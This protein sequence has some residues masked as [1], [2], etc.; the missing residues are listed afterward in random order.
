MKT[1]PEASNGNIKVFL[2]KIKIVTPKQYHRLMY[3][4]I[5]YSNLFSEYFFFFI[6]FYHNLL[7][8]VNFTSYELLYTCCSYEFMNL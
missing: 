7:V 6:K 2:M 4:H 5:S 8:T 1:E 3:A